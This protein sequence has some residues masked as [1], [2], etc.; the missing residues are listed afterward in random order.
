MIPDVSI[1]IVHYQAKP[2]LFA[3]LSSI[4]SSNIKTGYEVIVVDNDET[5]T[6][7]KQLTENFPWVRYAKASG[8]IG[9]GA[10]NN[11][12]SRIAIGKYFFFLNPDTILEKG[13]VD[14]LIESIEAGK[15]IGIIAPQ[16]IDTKSN[17]L[18]YQCSAKLTPLSGLISH[19]VINRIYPNNP[20]SKKYW[21]RDWDRKSARYVEVVQ[22]AAF[23]VKRKLFDEIGGFDEQF[24]MYFEES[25]FCLRTK[26]HGWSIVFE[27]RAKV[28]HLS[29]KSTKDKPRALQIFRNSR[30]YYFNKHFGQTT[31]VIVQVIFWMLDRWK[32]I[33]II[34]V[35]VVLTLLTTKRQ[36]LQ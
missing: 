14:L 15:N 17:I 20:I 10:G 27:P 25:D 6:I 9:F 4:I 13:S 8:N 7:G 28:I 18:P 3:C 22:G 11:L 19:S 26:Q 16:L 21:L 1:I 31:G 24:F 12:G 30:T 34:L 29:E 33:G 5:K 35:F 36:L 23:M 32:A 2:E